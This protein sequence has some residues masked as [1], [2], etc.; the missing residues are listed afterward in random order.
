MD[1]AE[2]A[3]N[4]WEAY[5]SNYGQSGIGPASYYQSG[6][7]YQSYGGE[8]GSTSSP[9]SLV[10]V[11]DDHSCGIWFEGQRKQQPTTVVVSRDDM[12]F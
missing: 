2:P 12:V 1:P 6:S 9:A 11:A 5:Y 8:S 10:A 7:H 4:S 3:W